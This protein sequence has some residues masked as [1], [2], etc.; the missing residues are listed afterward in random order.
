MSYELLH[1]SIPACTGCLVGMNNL[2]ATE[3]LRDRLQW[4]L[5]N[6]ILLQQNAQLR[7][8]LL[9]RQQLNAEVIELN[10][11]LTATVKQCTAELAKAEYQLTTVLNG[12]HFT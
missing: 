10:H 12:N 1:A 2:P 3:V 4:Q 5:A 7:A 9:D 6:R 11:W 8:D